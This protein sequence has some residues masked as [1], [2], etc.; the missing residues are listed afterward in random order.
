MQIA[1]LYLMGMRSVYCKN[2]RKPINNFLKFIPINFNVF[3]NYLYCLK[4]NITLPYT[5]I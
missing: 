2:I 4:L 3:D 1:I 5:N